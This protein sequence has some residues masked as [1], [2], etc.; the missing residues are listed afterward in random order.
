MSTMKT[1]RCQQ[2]SQPFEARVADRKRGWARYCSKQCKAVKQES[3]TGQFAYHEGRA[4]DDTR[5]LTGD[6]K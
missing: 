2:C 1:Y 5:A 3:I 4:R 6:D